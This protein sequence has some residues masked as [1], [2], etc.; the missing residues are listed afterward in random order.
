MRQT[1][2]IPLALWFIVLVQSPLV[3]A[4]S[5]GRPNVLFIA[6]DDMNDWAGALGGHP[7]ART[8]NLDRLA[9]RGML[10]TNA[11]CAAPGCNSSRTALLTGM[12]PS[13]TG[14]YVNAHDWR[15]CERLSGVSTLPRHFHDNGYKTIGGG[16]IFHAHTFNQWALSGHPDPEAWDE[17]FPSKTQQLPEEVIP[18]GWPVNSKKSFYGGHFDW[19]PLDIEDGE[20]ADA[21]VVAWAER[22][23]SVEHDKPVFLAVGI[24]RPHVPWYVPRSYFEQYPLDQV[25]LP[26]V[27]DGDLDDVPDAGKK[28]TKR[29]WHK[30]IVENQQWRKA[31]QAYLA[32]MNFADAMLG[33]VLSAWED[34]PLAD[35]TVVVLW[36]DH[37]YHLGVKEHWEKFALWNQ[38]THVPLV[39]ADPRNT[40]RGS[41]SDQPV[42][43]L[44]IYPT[45]IQLCGLPEQTYLQGQSLVPLLRNPAQ[46]TGRSVVTTQGFGNHAVRSHRYRYIRY[47]DGAE[48]L[49]DHEHDPLEWDNI[50]GQENYRVVQQNLAG[51]L[52]TVNA[53]PLRNRR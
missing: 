38:T 30:W 12:R 32:S 21:K 6:I 43:L 41:R 49:Y 35:N 5:D 42:S 16:K 46:E 23:L 37:G 47:A 48:E 34:G 2:L 7:D 22:Q 18:E 25:S 31:V 33:R 15:N 51:W 17:Y 10:F 44:D 8:P 28:L 9:E 19:S 26:V 29:E 45:L 50:A 36:S 24:Y 53:E 13:T 27:K 20:M 1:N 4:A 3:W 14:V 52:P 40:T 11:H 39:F